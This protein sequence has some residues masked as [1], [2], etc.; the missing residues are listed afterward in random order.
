M[1]FNSEPLKEPRGFLRLIQW[2]IAMLAF[3]TACDF[4]V[5]MGFTIQ[6]NQADNNTA[7]PLYFNTTASY[8]FRLDHGQPI[9][10]NDTICGP[11]I[12]KPHEFTFPGDFSSDA[13]FFVFMG[14]MVWL[15]S[16][17]SLALYVFYSNLYT[18]QQKSYPKIDFLL[19]AII[20]FIWLAASSAWA[21][22]FLNMQSIAY[23]SSW[24]Y[25]K[26]SPCEKS[27]DDFT[28][29]NIK[30]CEPFTPEGGFGTG[31]ASILFG[32]LNC[33]LWVSNTWFLYKETSWYRSRNP[34]MQ[35]N[36]I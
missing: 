35:A 13:Q 15:Y 33:F 31:N 21:N 26:D 34:D 2:F 29:T 4:S 19:A 8:P 7:G 17:A 14:V 25:G 32:F 27:N 18:D 11:N 36:G 20:A 3:A 1:P 9:L 12:G 5:K 22:G 30:S 10:Y 24:I 28:N 16:M 23:G 6:C